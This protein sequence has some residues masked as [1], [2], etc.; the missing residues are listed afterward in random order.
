MKKKKPLENNKTS[1]VVFALLRLGSAIR[2]YINGSS[3]AVGRFLGE[4]G[5]AFTEP[6][7][8]K[9]CRVPRPLLGPSIPPPRRRSGPNPTKSAP[10]VGAKGPGRS[11]GTLSE[12][13]FLTYAVSNPAD[14]LR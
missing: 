1:G 11:A 7:T 9:C 12:G 8:Y 6:R 3:L 5:P 10:S 14:G 13:S 4:G 2:T